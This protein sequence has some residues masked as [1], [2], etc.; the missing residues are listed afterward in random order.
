[1]QF[2]DNLDEITQMIQRRFSNRLIWKSLTDEKKYSGDY[3][4]F[5]RLIKKEFDDKSELQATPKRVAKSA[6]VKKKIEQP[7][8]SKNETSE[9]EK[10][11]DDGPL[12]FLDDIGGPSKK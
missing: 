5:C 1:M 6:P 12:M 9:E 10:E 4:H 7:S 8:S 2:Y 3:T 11:D